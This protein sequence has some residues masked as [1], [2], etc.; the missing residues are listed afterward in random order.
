MAICEDAVD[1]AILQRIMEAGEEG[2][3]PKDLA[4]DLSNY[5][6]EQVDLTRRIRRMNIRLE[7]K[8]G[9]RVAKKRGEKWLITTFMRN[10]L[11]IS[12]NLEPLGEGKDPYC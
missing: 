10:L 6:L 7:R 3:L 2:I 12:G 11:G 8:V 9:K 4:K 1:V 5:R